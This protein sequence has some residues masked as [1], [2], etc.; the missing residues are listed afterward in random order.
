MHLCLYHE[1]VKS[2][3]LKHDMIKRQTKRV[4]DFE[5]V[6]DNVKT[7]VSDLLEDM[8]NIVVTKEQTQSDSPKYVIHYI[9]DE[10]LTTVTKSSTES[11]AKQSTASDILIDSCYGGGDETEL[12]V[13]RGRKRK[14]ER[15]P[16]K[17]KRNEQKKEEI[18]WGGAFWPQWETPC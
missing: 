14:R 13:G 15:N 11:H 2:C 1:Q 9:L 3:V 7:T 16:A 4:L 12:D 6:E 17:W 18:F 10:I 8:I 5:K